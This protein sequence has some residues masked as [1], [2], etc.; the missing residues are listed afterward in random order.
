[1]RKTLFLLAVASTSLLFP[2]RASA[3]QWVRVISTDEIVKHIDVDSIQVEGN[4]RKFWERTIYP[5]GREMASK[6]INVTKN[7]YNVNC[8]E[9]TVKAIRIVAYDET[10]SVVSDI[11]IRKNPF[12]NFG[13]TEAV[14]GTIG[15]SII[16]LVC[17]RKIADSY[18][19]NVSSSSGLSRQQATNLVSNWLKGKRQ[20]FSPPFSQIVL[21]ELATGKLYADSINSINWLRNNNARY[22]Y[23]FQKIESVEAFSS[24]SNRAVLAVRVTEDSTLFINGRIDPKSSG[25]KTRS[26]RYNL[27]LVNGVWK[28]GD[29]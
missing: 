26:I 19:G 14:P 18:S 12:I 1:M 9:K 13:S 22:E 15:D 20:I 7:L 28:I 16:E 27:Q 4:Q 21:S 3:T 25:L 5:S 17:N 23:G 2:I 29:Y 8:L 6:V 10:G 11:D 24:T